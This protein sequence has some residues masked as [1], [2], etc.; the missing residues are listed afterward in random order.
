MC[1]KSMTPT[2]KIPPSHHDS[3]I[4]EV[5]LSLF[6]VIEETEKNG[7]HAVW[8]YKNIDCLHPFF[9][10]VLAVY[11]QSIENKISEINIGCELETLFK[12]ICFSSPLEFADDAVPSELLDP[13][14]A[15]EQT[16]VCKFSRKY[17]KIDEMQSELFSIFSEQI[18]HRVEGRAFFRSDEEGEQFVNLPNGMYWDGTIILVKIPLKQ[19]EGFDVYK[20]IE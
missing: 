8:D 12:S 4:G 11:K 18:R 3:R 5:L 6:S 14:K 1:R 10:S 20:F 17:A 7:Q 19:K 15:C 16:P 2:I 13:Y 9:I